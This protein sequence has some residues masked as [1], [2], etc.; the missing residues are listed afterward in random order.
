M[1]SSTGTASCHSPRAAGETPS[2]VPGCGAEPVLPTHAAQPEVPSEAGSRPGAPAA[3]HGPACRDLSTPTRWETHQRE[4]PTLQPHRKR[5]EIGL[6]YSGLQGKF[7]QIFQCH[8]I[9]TLLCLRMLGV[10]SPGLI[11]REDIQCELANTEVRRALPAKN[12][13]SPSPGPLPPGPR[14]PL[15]GGRS[16]PGTSPRGY[17]PADGSQV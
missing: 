16:S 6:D 7:L 5:R 12:G 17:S 1:G 2:Q 15:A 8:L 14:R 11:T 9:L 13:P 10:R 3:P 4:W